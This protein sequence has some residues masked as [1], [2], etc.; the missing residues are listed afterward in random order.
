MQRIAI[1]D[2]SIIATWLK[3][4]RWDLNVFE[5]LPNIAQI[6]FRKGARATEDR[7]SAARRHACR[8]AGGQ[9]R[10]RRDAVVAQTSAATRRHG[11]RRR[12]RVGERTRRCVLRRAR[13]GD[14]AGA[15]RRG[16]PRS[17]YSA[18]P[19]HADLLIASG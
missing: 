19:A 17:G 2:T 12:A 18:A 4:L 5:L 8:P 7:R 14:D 10:V 3:L 11:A 13:A 16:L 9:G 15:D 6:V 1:A